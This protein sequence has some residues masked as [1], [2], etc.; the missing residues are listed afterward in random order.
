MH[1]LSL[2][3]LVKAIYLLEPNPTGPNWVELG[4]LL[5]LKLGWIRVEVNLTRVAPPSPSHSNLSTK[6]HEKDRS[7]ILIVTFNPT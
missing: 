5:G 4:W 1:V 3:V 7:F 2:V 6:S